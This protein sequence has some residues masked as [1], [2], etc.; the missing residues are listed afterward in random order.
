MNEKIVNYLK[1][2]KNLQQDLYNKY[3]TLNSEICNKIKKIGDN[4]PQF[5][6]KIKEKQKKLKESKN[7]YIYQYS[8]SRKSSFNRKDK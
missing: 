4:L 5:E 6:S 2:E 8:K 3:Y 1:E 7:I